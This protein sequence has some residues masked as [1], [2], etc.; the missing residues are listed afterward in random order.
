M[1]K[2]AFYKIILVVLMILVPFL[3]LPADA[4]LGDY[5]Y[6]WG[7]LYNFR[8]PKDIAVDQ[9]GN[10]YVASNWGVYVFSNTGAFLRQWGTKGSGDGQYVAP[11]GITVDGSGNVYVADSSS[12]KVQVFS[13]DGKFIR[14]LGT[15][16][17]FNSPAGMAVDSNGNV[18]IA[19]GRNGRIQVFSS[20]GIFL[21]SWGSPGSGDGQFS[22]PQAI[23]IDKND[24]VYVAERG[25]YRVQ[26][27][28]STGVFL[29]KWG[30]Y[31]SGDGQFKSPFGVAVDSDGNVFVADVSTHSIQVFSNTGEFIR[32]W[33]AYGTDDGLFKDPQ[34]I[35]M[36]SS[37]SIFVADYGN[38]RIQAFSS[39]GAFLRKWGV[40]D[41]GDGF[42]YMPRGIAI[43]N[44]GNAYVVDQYNYRVQV[45]NSDGAFLTKWGSYGSRD[46]EFRAPYGITVD[47]SGKI[48]VADTYNHRVE[49]FSSTGTFLNKWG[50][51]GSGD[52]QLSEPS[53]IAADETG[54]VYIASSKGVQVFSNTGAFLERWGGSYGQLKYPRGIAVGKSSGNLYV[55][56]T[57]NHRVQVVSNTGAFL[58]K[59][60][61]LGSGNGQFNYPSGVAVDSNGNVYVA[62]TN[63][64]RVQVFSSTGTFLTKWGTYGSDD[65][66]FKYPFGIA[67]ALNGKIY[68]SDSGNQRVQVF[69]GYES[70][71]LTADAGPAQTVEQTSPFGASIILSGSSTSHGCT[72]ALTYEWTWSGGSATGA[73]PTVT[74]PPGTTNVTLTVRSGTSSAAD[75]VAV[76]VRD[77][78]AP[79]TIAILNGSKGNNGWYLSD[80]T[81][82]LSASDTGSGVKESHY[83]VNSGV[84]VA[85]PGS[86]AS[87]SLTTD[88]G[89]TVSYYA[90]DNADNR[91][92]PP[93][94][95]TVNI[96]KTPPTITITGVTTGAAYTLGAAPTA[97][98][99]VM[100]SLSGVATETANLTG[101]NVNGVGTYAYTV[102]ATDRAGNTANATVVYNVVYGFG[103]FLPPV[104]LDKPFKLGSTIPVKFQ[105][106][107]AKGSYISTAS[108]TIMVQQF[109]DDQPVG[110]PIGV[111]STSAADMGNTFRYSTID[112]L[113]LYNLSTDGLYEGIW[114]IRATLDD[115]TVKTAFIDL[116]AK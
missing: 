25:N 8:Y 74:L 53:G 56:D 66:Q 69:E 49:V 108:A 92:N 101:G 6:K 89:F 17:Q 75:S 27:F 30:I 91:E 79:S 35:V 110:E 47:E 116:K 96:D 19:D 114:Q 109:S 43:D 72:S 21:R 4:A 111:T 42:F 61:T 93:N 85:V 36:D 1:R 46:G 78:Q 24:N 15:D 80:V 67:V 76:T 13:V 90:I 16:G 58:E 94:N 99:S 64:H 9:S 31:G 39:T 65:G 22:W 51:L 18:Y 62:D 11:S 82:S 84:D 87:V 2:N 113:Y 26:V 102:N 95:V 73:N 45:F 29:R 40:S 41:T 77:T 10:F 112:N 57:S 86:F 106:T 28:S 63:N 107:G 14:K 71:V 83:Q 3:S 54:N 60:G 20:T 33:G 12:S 59:W 37:G 115:G 105:L 52:G 34:G 55:A 32:K 103:G 44:S 48:Y 98:Y 97:G 38:D 100:D 88:G 5:L 68:V 104:N 7:G 50:T 81:V 23:A 70:C